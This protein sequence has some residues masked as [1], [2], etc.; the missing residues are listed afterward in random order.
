MFH[1][2]FL[3][4]IT[5]VQNP[6]QFNNGLVQMSN[7]EFADAD[8]DLGLSRALLMDVVF[9]T[10][11]KEPLP[12]ILF[13]HGGGWSGG[14]RQDGL[15]A[16]QMVALGGYFA[17]T[18]DYRLTEE[19]GF[20][21]AVHDCK[22]AIKFLRLNSNELGIDPNRIGIVGYS[23]GGH[24]AALVGFSAGDKYLDGAINGEAVSTEVLCI[25]SI[26][27]AVMPQVARGKG[28]RMYEEWALKDENVELL[29]TLPEHYLDEDD[30]P[31]YLLC[32]EDD[33]VCPV[34]L[35]Q[36]FLRKVEDNDVDCEIVV[37]P[38]Q[39]HQITEPS[40]YLGLLGFLD[41]HLGGHAQSSFK[42][43]LNKIE[44]SGQGRE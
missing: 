18:I 42:E 2:I 31:I 20:P 27:G 11:A 37:V 23:A 41:K 33:K 4:S 10:E 13:L 19:G 3:L 29:M 9:P 21:A 28:K 34:R 25:G 38:N 43:Y 17:A 36:S 35:T 26:S 12:A 5:V 7:I 30:P 24:L 8:S 6:I 1:F 14:K 32:G 22:A 44:K 39:G 16:I 15:K 40:A